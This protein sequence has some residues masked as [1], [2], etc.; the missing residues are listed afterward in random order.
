MEE[1]KALTAQLIETMKESTDELARSRATQA[2][3]LTEHRALRA[4][5]R[6]IRR[7]TR[8]AVLLLAGA[9]VAFWWSNHQANQR[10]RNANNQQAADLVCI[11]L[12]E[13]AQDTRSSAL[14]SKANSRNQALRA[15]VD[16]QFK[17]LTYARTAHP[18][19]AT[20]IHLVDDWNAKTEAFRRA[21]NA[22]TK[23]VIDNP[24]PQL[25][26]T[27]S[28][29]L[30]GTRQGGPLPTVTTTATRTATMTAPGSTSTAAVTVPGPTSTAVVRMPG[31]TSTVVVR[32]PGTTRTRTVT[33]TQAP[34]DCVSHP[35]PPC[36][37][38]V[39]TLPRLP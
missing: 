21:D 6:K 18:L 5:N 37:L 20:I 30:R 38:R 34:P 10:V 8:I 14:A 7:W 22:Y 33:T 27:C 29:R 39:P 9:V 12:H 35:M 24:V 3:V 2:Q 17:A 15:M 28:D 25:Q 23:A 16:A 19:Q 32:E 1:L 26:F 4:A 11:A 31:S 13:D 36:T